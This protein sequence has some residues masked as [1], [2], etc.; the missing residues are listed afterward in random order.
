M[1]ANSKTPAASKEAAPKKKG[2]TFLKSGQASWNL[3]LVAL[4]VL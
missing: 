4:F 2:L 3:M 1:A